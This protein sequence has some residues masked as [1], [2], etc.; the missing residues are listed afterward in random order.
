MMDKGAKTDNTN[1]AKQDDALAPLVAFEQGFTKHMGAANKCC[2]CLK[3]STAVQLIGVLVILNAVNHLFTFFQ[4]SGA[5]CFF[6]EILYNTPLSSLR[7]AETRAAAGSRT[8]ARL[9]HRPSSLCVLRRAGWKNAATAVTVVLGIGVRFAAVPF[10][11]MGVT[12]ARK[13][14][15]KGPRLFFYC[16]LTLMG[17]QFLDLFL[18]IFEVHAVCGGED[19]EN[20]NGCAHDWGKNQYHCVAI[21]AA[22]DGA[23]VA[24]C[25]A[26]EQAENDGIT[27]EGGL[28]WARCSAVPGCQHVEMPEAAWVIPEC[29]VHEDWA[30]EK[31]P[32][33]RAPRERKAEFDVA[34]CEVRG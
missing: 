4:R 8:P 1:Q 31:G 12:G 21:D 20:W 3:L 23:T 18:C 30:H 25:A 10:A 14:Q 33:N 28:D 27:G 9:V 7:R 32:C 5:P 24:A 22:A 6:C 26:V 13:A 15:D 29:C 34:G 2:G 17:I 11:V 19:L 16:L